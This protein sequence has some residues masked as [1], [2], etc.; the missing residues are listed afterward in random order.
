MG[1]LVTVSAARGGVWVAG[2]NAQARS[3]GIEPGMPLAN[4]RALLPGLEARPA[5]A[6]G[7]ARDLRGLASA[8]RRY[9]PWV[10]VDP[11]GGGVGNST[12]GGGLWLEVTGCTHL[13]GG[14]QALLGDLL[15][16]LEKS[17]YA[18]R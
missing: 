3:A 9:T 5:D 13:F 12:G 18:A 7:E 6:A 15:G 14:P 10:A 8:C 4:A 16:R 11:Q 2:A 1:A 17:G